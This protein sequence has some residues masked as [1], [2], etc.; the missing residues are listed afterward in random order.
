MNLKKYFL[1]Y[2]IIFLK[3]FLELKIFDQHIVEANLK[4]CTNNYWFNRY[5]Y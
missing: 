5:S 1:V 3:T 2:F 4:I